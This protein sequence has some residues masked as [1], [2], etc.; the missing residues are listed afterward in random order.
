[1]TMLR[2]MLSAFVLAIPIG[3]IAAPPVLSEEEAAGGQIKVDDQGSEIKAA[4]QVHLD[5]AQQAAGRDFVAPLGLCNQA[6]P[7]ALRVVLPAM[8]VLR[9]AGPTTAEQV[10]AGKTLEEI[11]ATGGYVRSAPPPTKVLD[12]LVYLGI[13]DATAWAVLTSEGIVL[14]DS[15]NNRREWIDR[16]EPGMRRIGLKPEDI[17]YVIVTHGHGDH[18]G[19]AAY[20]QEKYGARV[21]MSAVDW[22]SAPRLIDKPWFDA[23]PPQD[24]V[25]ADGEKLTLG[26]TTIT[27][28][29]TPGHTR[30]TLSAL[31]PVR[32]GGVPH[33]AALWGGT[34]F[35]F[36]HTPERFEVYASSA[37]RFRALAL[38]AG[39]DIPLSPHAEQDS[40]IHKIE[41]IRGSVPGEA[42][43]FI[44]GPD[45]VGRFLT[46]FEQCALAY[47]SQVTP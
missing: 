35:N 11:R 30:G 20:L 41:R 13:E 40:A 27:L 32:D 46:T 3:A 47:K 45:A 26:D 44:M 10:R 21:V 8:E 4:T 9:G 38:A 29:I 33:V 14:I 31:I 16:I 18:F 28:Y 43:P 12:N 7:A 23:P 37:A 15:L 39:A 6:R 1:M 22:E 25:A 2:G 19:G 34:G 17:K 36:P 42:N 5:R 24:I